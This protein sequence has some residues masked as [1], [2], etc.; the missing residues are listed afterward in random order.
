MG[1]YTAHNDPLVDKVVSQH[2]ARIV[3]A[4]CARLEPQA[5]FLYGSFGRGEGSVMLADGQLTFL[6]DYEI[7]VVTRSPFYRSLFAELSQQLTAEMGVEV[8]LSWM[9]PGR[10]RSNQAQNLSWGPASPTIAMY[11]IKAGGQ[12]LYGQELLKQAPVINPTQIS[13]RAGIRL[14]INRMTEALHYAA[15]PELDKS[16]RLETIRWMNKLILACA[17]SL[18]LLWKAYHYSYAER[19]RRF[20]NK[21]AEFADTLPPDA[22]LL[23]ELVERATRF[24]LRPAPDIYPENVGNMWP[25]IISVVDAAFSHLMAQELGITYADYTQFPEQFLK[26]PQV[27]KSYNL[28]R[29]WPLPTPLDQKLINAVKYLRKK[30]LPPAGYWTHFSITANL[31]VFGLAPVLFLGTSRGTDLGAINVEVRKWLTLIGYSQ[32]FLSNPQAEWNNLYH[33]LLWA[34][35]NFCYN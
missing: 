21:Y 32:P 5:I 33:Y 35:K 12:T 30:Q 14:L 2:F 19:G 13:A 25:Q 31:I 9:R 6:S 27:Q 11:E 26:H 10:L 24:K 7:S 8:S 1:K 4:I 18:L 17:E 34:W 15:H 20:A 29:L 16:N 3:D 22:A 23:P 28:Y